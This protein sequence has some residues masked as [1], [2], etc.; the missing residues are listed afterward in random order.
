MIHGEGVGGKYN[1][2][3]EGRKA[4][5]FK[6]VTPATYDAK[7]DELMVFKDMIRNCDM[8][9]FNEW[10]ELYKDNHHVVVSRR[11]RGIIED[12]QDHDD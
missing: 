7:V 6:G 1:V 4:E 5:L 8:S 9:Q 11:R 3:M 10:Y 2:I 12:L